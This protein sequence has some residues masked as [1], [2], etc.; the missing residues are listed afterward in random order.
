M[1]KG[2]NKLHISG[3][4]EVPESRTWIPQRMV[5]WQ[6]RQHLRVSSWDHRTEMSLIHLGLD[7]ESPHRPMDWNHQSSAR[8][9]KSRG[10]GKKWG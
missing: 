3:N 5:V 9:L 6:K 4:F 10:S 8:A 1:K 7:H 2:K